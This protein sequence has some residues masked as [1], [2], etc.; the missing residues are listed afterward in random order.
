MCYIWALKM[1][2]KVAEL[3]TIES[4]DQNDNDDDDIERKGWLLWVQISCLVLAALGLV[5]KVYSKC[6]DCCKCCTE[7]HCNQRDEEEQIGSEMV[8]CY[9]CNK[10]VARSE[11]EKQETG[12]RSYCA[13]KSKEHRGLFSIRHF[14]WKSQFSPFLDVL[15]EMPRTSLP[16]DNCGE[17]LRIW[18]S[19]MGP[20]QFRC[21]DDECW[22]K[23]DIIHN[24]GTN[25][26]N[27]FTC[28]LDLCRECGNAEMADA[29]ELKDDPLVM[30]ASIIKHRG[31]RASVKVDQCIEF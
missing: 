19:N 10:K 2:T 14:R 16:C 7:W 4:R 28:D 3:T 30:A 6:K 1:F 18:P 27:C 21:S 23:G 12:H 24:D 20:V 8:I 17:L 11:W 9:L 22:S 31:S 13:V 26:F 29:K 15:S 25:R 5:A